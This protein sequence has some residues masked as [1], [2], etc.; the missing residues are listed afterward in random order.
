M[1]AQVVGLMHVHAPGHALHEGKA[2][3]LLRRARNRGPLCQSDSGRRRSPGRSSPRDH[4]RRRRR[5]P[6]PPQD[7]ERAAAH[8]TPPRPGRPRYRRRTQRRRRRRRRPRLRAGRRGVRAR[9]SARPGG[10]RGGGPGRIR[11]TRARPLLRRGPPVPAR[12]ARRRRRHEPGG[13][14]A[15]PALGL[16]SRRGPRLPD[17]RGVRG[18]GA[19]GPARAHR[20]DRSA[21]RRG[22]PPL[23]PGPARAAGRGGV[24]EPARDG[25]LPGR[26][27][28]GRG[29]PLRAL[30]TRGR[31]AR[32]ARQGGR[33]RAARPARRPLG[34]ARRLRRARPE[35][36]ARA[37]RPRRRRG[38]GHPP[39]LRPPLPRPQR[40]AFHHRPQDRPPGPRAAAGAGREPRIPAA[41]RDAGLRDLHARLLRARG[42]A[43]SDLARV[44][45]PACSRPAAGLL[46]RPHPAAAAR[47]LRDSR[48]KAPSPR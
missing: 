18:H 3:P 40:G 34:R 16:R 12:A 38:Q 1:R 41:P 22:Q 13:A 27:P 35:R 37:R 20:P 26:S 15:R 7:R 14:R 17:G 44:P 23:V 4:A 8:A 24:R 2:R 9:A 39:R 6:P 42:G 48:R 30:R 21:A 43:A 11:A 19:R 10:G 25:V 28:S 45:A 31:P 36:A 32:A 29:G 5:F 33:G 47:H 46:P